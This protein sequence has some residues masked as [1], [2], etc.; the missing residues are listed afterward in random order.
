MRRKKSRAKKKAQPKAKKIAAR[1]RAKRQTKKEIEIAAV[2][3]FL[4]SDHFKANMKEVISKEVQH[5][6]KEQRL[7]DMHKKTEEL[8]RNW[9]LLGD[10]DEYQEEQNCLCEFMG[11][12]TQLHLKRVGQ[13]DK[14]AEMEKSTDAFSNIMK[15][16]EA[17]GIA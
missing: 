8:M 2:Q 10:G 4:G 7:E 17:M 6:L 12:M 11:R 9:S 3:K 13:L 5:Q 1:K 15:W 16:R 14:A